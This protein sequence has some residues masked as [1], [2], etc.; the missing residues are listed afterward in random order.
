MAAF[1]RLAVYRSL[2]RNVVWR[3]RGA[4]DAANA[5]APE[6]SPERALRGRPGQLRRRSRP[7][8]ALPARRAHGSSSPG[9]PRAGATTA[10]FPRISP[11]LP[12]TSSRPSTWRYASARPTKPSRRSLSIG[13]LGI[14]GIHRL[15]QF[16]WA[17]HEWLED[18]EV[19]PVRRDVR[20][21]AYRDEAH[22]VRWLDLTPLAASLVDR[23]LAGDPLADAVKARMRQARGR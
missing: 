2:V 14:R 4:D 7:A 8:D 6:R 20:I 19:A 1:P 3:R 15:Q 11:I 16:E 17:V 12:P 10:A 13:L 23:L 18:T 9:L 5:E 22:A 21:L